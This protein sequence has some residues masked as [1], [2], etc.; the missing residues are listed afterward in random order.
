[1]ATTTDRPRQDAAKLLDVHDVAAMLGCSARHV[2]RLSD[3]GHMPRP[4]KLGALT[5]WRRDA[6]ERWIDAGCPADGSSDGGPR[7]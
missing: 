1:M 4:L 7:R 3:A 2:Y 6:I 5:R